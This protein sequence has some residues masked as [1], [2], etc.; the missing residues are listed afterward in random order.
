LSLVVVVVLVLD[1]VAVVLLL[2]HVLVA[3][4]KTRRQSPNQRQA[5]SS[6]PVGRAPQNHKYPILEPYGYVQHLRRQHFCLSQ[7]VD[8]SISSVMY[9]D[10][11]MNAN[12]ID[13]LFKHSKQES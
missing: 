1:V 10:D 9:S 12:A 11:Q 13:K 8:S 2:G 4:V 3:V 5:C 7:G 6:H